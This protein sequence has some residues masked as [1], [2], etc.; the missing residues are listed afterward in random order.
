MRSIT[1]T[2]IC[3][4]ITAVSN[5]LNVSALQTFDTWGHERIQLNDTS[6]HFRYSASGKPPILLV[7]GFPQH[8][9]T[10]IHIG[11]ILAEKYT[12][13]APDNRGSGESA[14]SNSDNYTALAAAEDLHAVLSFL[15]ITKT[16]VLAHDKGVGIATALAFEHP[17]MVERLAVVEYP[18]PG[19][20]GYSTCVSSPSLYHDW[21]LSFFAVP[22]AA[23]FFIRGR[24]KEMLAWYFYHGS[25]SGNDV[26]SNDLLETYTRAI[27]KPG[28][29]RA[30]MQYF[31]AAFWDKTY[32]T[33]K[34]KSMGKLQMPVLAM[35][36]E[37]SLG[38]NSVL[39]QNFSPF[40]ANLTADVIPKAGHW[41]VRIDHH[42][43]SL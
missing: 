14:L 22:D 31:A 9:R 30:G 28:F 4:A 39:E 26:I 16:Y 34:V 19:S 36:G 23:E 25:Y 12:V 17:E 32:F 33:G 43:Q 10:W 24:E 1:L 42:Y 15:N 5:L 20:A 38:V 41:I 18:L 2:T 13:I 3:I 8:S 7:H 40:A 35:G 27:S 37:A 21:Q 11:P 6:I 29:L